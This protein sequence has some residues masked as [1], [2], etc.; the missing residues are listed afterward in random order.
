MVEIKEAPAK[1]FFIQEEL[2]QLPK[3]LQK[4]INKDAD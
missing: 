1:D 3:A 4:L 2:E